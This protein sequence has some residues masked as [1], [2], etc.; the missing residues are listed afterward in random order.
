MRNARSRC[1]VHHSPEPLRG[2]RQQLLVPGKCPVYDGSRCALGL[3]HP[4]A[5]VQFRIPSPGC[6]FGHGAQQR[7]VSLLS[8]EKRRP[9][10]RRRSPEAFSTPVLRAGKP[11]SGLR[12]RTLPQPCKTGSIPQHWCNG[13]TSVF[14]TED[15]SSTLVCCSMR[16]LRSSRES[17]SPKKRRN[18]TRFP[19]L[20]CP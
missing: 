3:Y 10:K 13:N 2:C 17:Y 16:V 1:S 9:C 5:S 6:A 12:S 19:A 11:G 4:I 7:S 20:A 14:Q 8:K 15:A 18:D